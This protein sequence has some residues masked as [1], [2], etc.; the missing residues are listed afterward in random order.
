LIGEYLPTPKNDLVRDHYA[1]L[2]FVRLDQSADGATR[3]ALDLDSVSAPDIFI[4]I[5]EG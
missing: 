2:G 5:L 1:G 4:D 3:Y